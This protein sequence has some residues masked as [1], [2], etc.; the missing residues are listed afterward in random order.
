MHCTL[1]S[2]ESISVYYYFYERSKEIIL[3]RQRLGS[4]GIST[5]ESM[6]SGLIAGKLIPFCEKKT[7]NNA[8]RLCND[9]H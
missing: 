6:L 3:R 7:L 4:K 5:L 8:Y 9:H 2:I 1:I